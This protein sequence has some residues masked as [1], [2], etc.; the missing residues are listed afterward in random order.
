MS[1][2]P[3]ILLVEG[4]RQY[5]A[6]LARELAADGFRVELAHSVVHARALAALHPPRLALL[7]HLE[8]RPARALLEEIRRG[9][10]GTRDWD[11]GLPVLVLGA[12]AGGLEALR[13]FEAGADDFAARPV[14]YLELRARL[15]AILR[16]TSVAGRARVLQ[17]GP[18]RVDLETRTARIYG[19]AIE[20]S[21]T[22]FELLAQL[23]LAPQRVFAR[24]ELLRS[25]WGDRGGAPTRTVDTHASRLRRKLGEASGERWVVGVRG[26]GYRLI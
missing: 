13:A 5:G 11:R 25:A 8:S 24:Q 15:R 3:A 19:R 26:L 4:D 9:G 2:G 7:G 22:E 6:A 21:R 1:T 20:L 12:E 17:A 23:A 16:R 10:E 18:L 14:S